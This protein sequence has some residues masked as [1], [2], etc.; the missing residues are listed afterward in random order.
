MKQL[1][2]FLRY[3]KPHKRLFF[4]TLLCGLIYGICSGFGIPVI[5]EWVFKKVFEAEAKSYTLGQIVQI[6]L[7]VPLLFSIRGLFGF[8]NTYFMGYCGLLIASNI[9]QALFKKLQEL[10]LS[11]FDT[12]KQGDLFHRVSSDTH[13]IQ[14]VLLELASELFKQPIQIVSA[15]GGL[16]Y[17][18][19]KHQNSIFLLIFLGITPLC[20]L[21]TRLIKKRLRCRSRHAQDAAGRVAH[22]LNESLQALIEIRSYSLE[23]RE[24]ARFEEHLQH[25][26]AFELK[27]LRYLKLQQPIMEFVGAILIAFVFIYAYFKGIPFSVF[28]AMGLG[29]YFALDP[30]KKLSNLLGNVHRTHGAIERVNEILNL[31]C[32]IQSPLHPIPF[33]GIQ[34]DIAFTKV[35]FAYQEKPVLKE[36][37]VH[38]PAHSTCALV[39]HSGAGKTTFSKL[40]P[41]FYDVSSGSITIDSKDIRN[42]SLPSLRKAIAVV[43]QH[44]V[45]F[46]DTIYNN[47]LLAAEGVEKDAVYQAAKNAFAHEFI[48]ELGGYET[49]VG[50]RGDRLSGGQKQRI[51]LARAFLKNAPILILDEATSA[52]DSESEHTIKEALDRLRVNKTVLIIAHRLSTIQKAD[53]ILVFEQ[54]SIVAEGTHESLLRTHP[55]YENWVKLQNL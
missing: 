8:L 15:I 55:V 52:L 32:P 45:L 1:F 3:L 24:Q 27:L 17:L 30:L 47:I 36:I 14:S 48:L 33:D 10:P 51:A 2:P 21:P 11:F 6:A 18:S 34:G 44:P 19:L 54:G 29:L 40:L 26:N 50:D 20:L 4:L 25:Y 35:S 16:A 41:R 13:A 9:K 42:L 12:H 23:K 38:I 28:S 39:G 43:S 7:L 31:P 22:C 5:F 53:K 37:S 46:H 49:I